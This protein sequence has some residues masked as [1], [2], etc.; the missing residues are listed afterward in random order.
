MTQN[1]KMTLRAL[2]NPGLAAAIVALAAGG[3]AWADAPDPAALP[4]DLS[5]A[6]MVSHADGVVR[7]VIWL[8]VMASLISWT[9]LI[10]KGSAL[11]NGSRRLRRAISLLDT[12]RGIP[13]A[14]DMPNAEAT[15][16]AESAL[17]EMALSHGLPPAGIKER[18]GSRLHRLEVALARQMARG[19]GIVA[20][21][22]AV[23]PFVGLFGTVWG[24]MNSFI[25]ISHSQA[26]SLAVVAPGIAE[27]LLA[28]AAG[29]VAAIPAVV[30][31]NLFAR[32]I[33]AYRGLLADLAAGI[34][35]Q[36][37]RVLDATAFAAGE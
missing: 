9:M 3:T 15:I 7:G 11:L 35:R 37:S 1:A 5:L 20:T 24:I 2:C 34:A 22:G 29:L 33:A 13:A 14:E 36:A 17:Q 31:Y 32:S 23:A 10:A 6:G 28:T 16:M 26:T 21:I 19:T 4:Q 12:Q 18:L 30:I 27:A 25:G 8:L